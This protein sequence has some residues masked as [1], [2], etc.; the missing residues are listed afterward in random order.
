MAASVVGLIREGKQSPSNGLLLVQEHIQQASNPK[1]FTAHTGHVSANLL[2]KMA[3]QQDSVAD[4]D[5]RNS[6]L[7][8]A[9]QEVEK[10]MQAIGPSWKK[11]PRFEKSIEML[12][13]LQRR[14]VSSVDDDDELEQ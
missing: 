8:G 10:A 4:G 9:L 7:S 2:F 12:K 14:I 5:V 1:I 11:S 3:Q 6:S 13:D